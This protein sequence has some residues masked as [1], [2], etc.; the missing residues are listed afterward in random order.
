MT[1]LNLD[2]HR[3]ITA[4]G[5]AITYHGRQ[6]MS[7]GKGLLARVS[8]RPP[9]FYTPDWPEYLMKYN[10]KEPRNPGRL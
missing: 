4:K 9:E 6:F 7:L 10:H 2:I 3:R 8:S 5:N 1:Y